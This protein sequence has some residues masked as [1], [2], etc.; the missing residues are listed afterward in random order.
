MV[1]H[2]ESCKHKFQGGDFMRKKKI[3]IK[4]MKL[5]NSYI[6]YETYIYKIYVFSCLIEKYLMYKK[7]ISYKETYIL[8]IYVFL[9]K[10]LRIFFDRRYG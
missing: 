3:D 9:Y 1:L 2:R 7:L 10:K 6:C 4:S 8:G 5:S